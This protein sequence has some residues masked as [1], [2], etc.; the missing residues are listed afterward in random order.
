MDA[1]LKVLR[2][3]RAVLLTP[4]HAFKAW[5][6]NTIT[7]HLLKRCMKVLQGNVK[8]S[9]KSSFCI[10][11]RM[12]NDLCGGI[13]FVVFLVV[14]N[15]TKNYHAETFL[16]HTPSTKCFKTIYTHTSYLVTEVNTDIQSLLQVYYSSILILMPASHTTQ[17]LALI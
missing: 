10:H 11:I 4:L 1:G 14:H 12:L 2:M 5:A 13:H 3:S 8:K 17:F 6:G 9:W 15:L 16:I 7:L